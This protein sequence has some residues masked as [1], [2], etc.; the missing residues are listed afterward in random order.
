MG[1][2]DHD[3]V[4][5]RLKSLPLAR[6]MA[7]LPSLDDEWRAR[8]RAE[9]DRGR[10][11]RYI[12]SATPRSVSARLAA[13]AADSPMGA[14][15]GTRNIISF[16]SDRY[17]D[18]PLVISGPGAGPAVTAAGRFGLSVGRRAARHAVDRNYIKRRA[19]E[20][21]R[22]HALK[23]TPLDVVL[24]LTSR[25]QPDLVDDL[26]RELGELMDRVHQRVPA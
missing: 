15:T 6:F 2:L 7:Q 12:V 5:A 10:V 24:T 3:L 26:V 8:T 18:E 23:R 9:A 11:L 22:R 17:K 14:A 20:A 16:T 13:V 19:R 4:P 21:F 25:F 1:R